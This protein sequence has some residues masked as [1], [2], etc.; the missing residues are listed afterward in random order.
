[1]QAAASTSH[2]TSAK[3]ETA[4]DVARAAAKHALALELACWSSGQ[5]TTAKLNRDAAAFLAHWGPATFVS[6]RLTIPQDPGPP[7]SLSLSVT[8][9]PELSPAQY[10]H[11]GYTCYC[12]PAAAVSVLQFLQ[13]TSH[14][15]ETLDQY[16]LAGLSAPGGW[17]TSSSSP[18][19]TKYLETNYW[20]GE[21]PWLAVAGDY[22]MNGTF[23]YWISGSYSGYPYYAHYA[24][25]SVSDYQSLL[26][27]DIW[28]A[29]APGFPLAGDVEEIGGGLHL[30]GHRTDLEIQHWIA[31]YGY[32]TGSGT[33]YVDP[34][35]GSSLG[36]PI[37]AYTVGYSSSNI[38]TLVTD[39]GPNGGP[40][41]IVW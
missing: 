7:G 13:P 16:V 19:S 18:Y 4:R 36:W 38:Y 32:T 2:V 15:G 25:T 34:A 20:G 31:M 9:Y 28:N 8:Q 23:N 39:A 30:P 37:D 10:C 6:Q 11:A 27:S 17:S 1:M 14:D 41:G 26:K 29:G 24:P 35:A 5:I 12:G 33:D 22:P 40:Y 21:T 3:H